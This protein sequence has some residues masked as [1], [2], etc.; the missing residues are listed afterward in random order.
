VGYVRVLRGA[1]DRELYAYLPPS[2]ATGDH[3]FPV[4]YMHDGRNLFDEPTSHAGEWRVDET[5]EELSREGLEAIVVGIPHGPERGAEYV[6]SERGSNYIAFLVDEVKP[7]VDETLRTLPGRTTTGLAGS[8]LGGIISLYGFLTRNDVFSYAG[9]MS[10]AF[11][12]DESLYDFAATTPR[13]EGRIWMD[14]GGDEHPD[15]PERSKA[16]LEGFER[17]S[18]IL[19]AQGYDESRLRTVVEPGALHHETAWA[20]RLPD[21]LRFLLPRLLVR[22]R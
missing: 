20:R 13:R 10:P 15:K 7:L 14:V 3:R 1:L 5:M 8:S 6:P 16:Y 22:R 18:S 11:W 12:W 17:M 4:L 9:V 19:R 2:Y 21:M